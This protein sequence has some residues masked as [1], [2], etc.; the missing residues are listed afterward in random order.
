[1]L[2]WNSL[3]TM[4]GQ[5]CMLLVVSRTSMGHSHTTPAMLPSSDRRGLEA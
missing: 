3:N 2:R 1:M 5:C 4:L